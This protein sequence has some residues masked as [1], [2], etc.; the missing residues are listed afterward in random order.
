MAGILRGPEKRF[1]LLYFLVA[2]VKNE[3]ASRKMRLRILVYILYA[4]LS[5]MSILCLNAKDRPVGFPPPPRLAVVLYLKSTSSEHLKS[6]IALPTALTC[7]RS[8]LGSLWLEPNSS[9]PEYSVSR[10]YSV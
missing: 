7:T 9:R 10:L 8:S 6:T 3:F 2:V 4:W 1:Q 5:A